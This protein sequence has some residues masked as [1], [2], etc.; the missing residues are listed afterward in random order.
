MSLNA[1][2][3]AALE[4][5][6]FACASVESYNYFTKRKHDLFGCFDIVAIGRGNV[7]FV[8]VTSA[9]NA[10]SRRHKILDCTALPAIREAKVLIVLSTWRKVKNR[11][12][13]TREFL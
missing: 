4:G 3:R 8:Q 9:S 5:E 7:L 11:W 2:T 12:T 6:G 10:S 13:E 1:R